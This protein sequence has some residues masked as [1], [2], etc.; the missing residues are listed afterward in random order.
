MHSPKTLTGEALEFWK[1]H[2]PGLKKTRKLSKS[3][4]Y[5]FVLLCQTW[6]QL[7]Q[8]VSTKPGADNYREMGQLHALRKDY[9]QLA[10]EFGLLPTRPKADDADGDDEPTDRFGI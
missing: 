5:S 3:S 2:A 1:A 6:D 7:Q 8:L 10:R 4:A 9:F